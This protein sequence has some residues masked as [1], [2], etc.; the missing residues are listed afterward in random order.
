MFSAMKGTKA[1]KRT[2]TSDSPTLIDRL[3]AEPLGITEIEAR[4]LLTQL[5]DAIQVAA[6]R[7][8]AQDSVDVN[9]AKVVERLGHFTLS[10]ARAMDSWV[11]AAYGNGGCIVQ[12]ER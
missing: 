9:L 10:G 5:L 4:S 11:A 7:S 3:K 12:P 6:K 2:S 8:G 1:R